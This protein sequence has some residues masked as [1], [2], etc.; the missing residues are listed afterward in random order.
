MRYRRHRFHPCAVLLL[1][2]LA[3]APTNA[4]LQ[5]TIETERTSAQQL[6]LQWRFAPT[7]DAE[8]F[9]AG[10]RSVAIDRRDRVYALDGQEQVIRVA[11][12][13]GHLLSTL[14]KRGSGPGELRG[15]RWVQILGDT[16]WVYDNQNARL[17]AWSTETLALLP[18]TRRGPLPLRL[19]SLSPRGFY[20]ADVDREE[21]ATTQAPRQWTIMHR[22]ANDRQ[23]RSLLRYDVRSPVLSYLVYERGRARQADAA[24]GRTNMAQP[25]GDSPLWR[26]RPDGSAF[27][28]VF[29]E[30]RLSEHAANPFAGARTTSILRVIDVTPTGDTLRELT[31]RVPARRVSDADIRSVV[32]S[33]R[34]PTSPILGRWVEADPDEIAR[35][36]FRPTNWPAVLEFFVEMD[37][38]IWLRQPQPP[39]PRAV[40]WRLAADG[41]QLPSVSLPGDLRIL[42]VHD[43]HAWGVRE[44]ADGQPGLERYGPDGARR[45]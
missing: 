2:V 26:T 10:V 27:T 7:R 28:M 34:L 32:D 39:S 40:F 17:T 23:D 11:S 5:V 24:V 37:G 19:E 35:N 22:V 38:T 1:S 12:R 31:V 3:S 44:D 14:G 21:A 25:L 33:L 36:L 15:A 29:R 13:D 4:Q 42:L 45:R 16:L 43:G 41:R 18:G 30:T 8:W 9:F 6:G 20:H